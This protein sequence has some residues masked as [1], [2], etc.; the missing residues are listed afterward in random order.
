MLWRDL[1]GQV[2]GGWLGGFGEDGMAMFENPGLP[3]PWPAFSEERPRTHRDTS[4]KRPRLGIMLAMYRSQKAL[5]LG[6]SK[7][8]LKKGFP[9]PLGPGVKKARKRVEKDYFS[10]FFSGFWLVFD[11]F[12]NFLGGMLTLG[13][14]A[15]GNPF[16]DF[17]RS[18]PGRRLLTPVDGQRYPKPRLRKVTNGWRATKCTTMLRCCCCCCLLLLLL[19]LSLLLLLLLL[20]LILYA[21]KM[22][23][24]WGSCQCPEMGPKVGKKVAFWVQKW[25]NMGRNPLFTHLKTYFGTLTKTHF[26]PL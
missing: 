6:N 4:E 13:P 15:P 20:L 23:L 3:N 24:R 12:L 1:Q 11:S 5:S 21:I 9:G 14:R 19:L 22:G 25:V 7:K 16:S 18:F 2:L 10:S 26:Y 8:S 17:F